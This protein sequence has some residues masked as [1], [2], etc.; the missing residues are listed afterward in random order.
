MVIML[1]AVA[2]IIVCTI[3]WVGYTK[4]DS[5]KNIKKTSNLLSSIMFYGAILLLITAMGG[6]R[7]EIYSIEKTRHLS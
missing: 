4:D 3:F 7:S 5:K 2:V 6:R 1:V